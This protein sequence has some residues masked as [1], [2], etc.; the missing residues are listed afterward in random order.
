MVSL[1]IRIVAAFG[2]AVSPGR[3]VLK[4]PYFFRTAGRQGP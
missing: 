2:V 1:K 4:F 3:K